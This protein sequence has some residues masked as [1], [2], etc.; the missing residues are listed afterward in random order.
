MLHQQYLTEVSVRDK[1]IFFKVYTFFKSYH[2]YSWF[3]VLCAILVF[4]N[5]EIMYLFKIRF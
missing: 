5:Q 3:H 4:K 1:H 2:V